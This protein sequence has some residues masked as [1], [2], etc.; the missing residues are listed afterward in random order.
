MSYHVRI[1]AVGSLPGTI[2]DGQNLGD[3]I[4]QS[5][6]KES[7]SFVLDQ[8]NGGHEDFMVLRVDF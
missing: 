7:N 6:F 2:N 5:V 1:Q 4:G 3:K 8:D